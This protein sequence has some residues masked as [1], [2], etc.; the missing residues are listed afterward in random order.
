MFDLSTAGKFR[1]S[2]GSRR[3]P[4]PRSP[5]NSGT[6][7]RGPDLFRQR[8]SSACVR[9]SV[10]NVDLVHGGSGQADGGLVVT[11]DER[12]TSERWARRPTSS[13]ALAQRCRIVLGCA[14]GKPNTQVAVDVG[15]W[16]QTVGVWH[17]RFIERRL[18]RL[19]RRTAPGRPTH[20]HRRAGR[21]GGG[22]HL[23]AGPKMPHIGRGPRWP[24]RPDCRNR[25]LAGSGKRSG[26]SLIR[27]TRS[28]C[29]MI[30]SSPTRPGSTKSS[31]GS[32]C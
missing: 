14:A 8:R 4:F 29:P 5:M 23:G 30:R 11:E 19:G 9:N 7:P 25:P 17:R 2:R 16:P 20:H 3:R 31:G 24:P 1:T 32:R 26:S 10:I 6:D 22:D 12:A 27:S 13:Q 18:G 21:G 28:N 15:V